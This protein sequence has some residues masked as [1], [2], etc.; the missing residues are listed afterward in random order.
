MQQ[1][2][3]R[4][5]CFTESRLEGYSTPSSFKN[6]WLCSADII[7]CPSWTAGGIPGGWVSG[8]D[9]GLCA[10]TECC[11]LYSLLGTKY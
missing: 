11:L 6:Y 2:A 9:P 1:L 8:A 10:I 7:Q 5:K 4:D 3:W